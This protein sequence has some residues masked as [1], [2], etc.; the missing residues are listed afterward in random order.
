M[1]WVKVLVK[2]LVICLLV[3]VFP[4]YAKPESLTDIPK[5]PVNNIYVTDYAGLLEPTLITKMQATAA[6]LDNI[7]GAQLVV[8]TVNSIGENPIEN[9]VLDLFRKWGIGSKVKNNGLLFLVVKDRLMAGKSGKV[10]IEVGY[11]LEG[12]IPDGKA[13]RILDNYVLPSW[14][15]GNYANG[16]YQGFMT[17]AAEVAKEYNVN[18]QS[19]AVLGSLQEYQLSQEELNTPEIVMLIVFLAIILIFAFLN[20]RHQGIGSNGPFG[21]G[22]G[23]YNKSGGFGGGGRGFGGG[24]S[25]GGGASR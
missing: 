12:A 25:G 9:Y 19:D 15:E 16:I 13:G 18:L 11:G 6:A 5:A 10:R 21:G 22:F 14:T 4:A 20:R 2:S 17:L 24:S 23:G 1:R 7:S 3:I 8:V